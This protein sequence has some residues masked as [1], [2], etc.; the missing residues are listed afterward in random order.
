MKK[1][2]YLI[3]AILGFIL[4][5]IFVVIESVETGNI[6]LYTDPMATINGMFGNRISSIF[7]I[8]LL[9]TV[10]VF[11]IWSFIEAKKHKMKRVYVVWVF[12]MLFGLA[13]GFPLFLYLREGASLNKNAA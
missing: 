12:T 8:D 3:L 2:I 13:G 7:S 1:Q 6:L 10:L 9:F 4:P 5:T 11:F